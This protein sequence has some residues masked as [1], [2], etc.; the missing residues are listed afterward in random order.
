MGREWPG[1]GPMLLPTYRERGLNVNPIKI[2]PGFS[3]F[4]AINPLVPERSY[5]T[6]RKNGLNINI[7]GDTQAY[8]SKSSEHLVIYLS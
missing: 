7:L 5:K 4:V 3:G 2:A 1:M 8:G 6:I